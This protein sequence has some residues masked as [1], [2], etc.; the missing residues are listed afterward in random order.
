MNS[1]ALAELFGSRAAESVLLHLYHYGETY[2]RAVSADFKI[3]LDSVQRNLE[4]F[5]RAGVLICKKNGRTL[6]YNWNPKSRLSKRLQDLVEIIYESMSLE[7]REI[8]FSTRR[9]HRS[10]DKPVIYSEP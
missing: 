8:I 4:K 7:T 9:R 2:G 10:K 1:T 3:S 5:E 6:I